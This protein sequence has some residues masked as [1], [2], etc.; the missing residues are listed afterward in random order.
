MLLQHKVYGALVYKGDIL[1][2][3]NPKVL[4]FPFQLPGWK[5]VHP[6]AGSALHLQVPAAGVSG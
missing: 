2:L 6:G 5:P 1:L 4:S 3:G